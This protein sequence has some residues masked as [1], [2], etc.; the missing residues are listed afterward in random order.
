LTNPFYPELVDPLSRYLAAHDLRTVLVTHTEHRPVDVDV[1]ADGSYDGVILTTTMRRSM[2][3]RDLTERGVPHVLVNRVLD[4]A[5]SPSCA[6]DNAAGA[7]AISELLADLG[8]WQIASIQGPTA[9]SNGR[10]RAEALRLGL[11]NRGV[12]LPR[13]MIRRVSFTH[14]G[15][16]VAATDLLQG[17]PRP[18]ALVCGNDVVAL[19]AMSAAARL[20]LRVPDEVT[21]IGFDDIPVASWPLVSLTTVRCDL[22]LLA[23]TAVDLLIQEMQ[24]NARLL[25]EVRRIPI[26]LQLRGT[27]ARAHPG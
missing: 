3:P 22:D 25:P 27:H 10:E 7:R 5:E 19:G 21:I 18:T 1:L 6:V 13:A 20:G 26:S 11:R 24:P 17:E 9:T 16:L 12:P 8:H 23:R 4:V 15:G 2:L 14:D